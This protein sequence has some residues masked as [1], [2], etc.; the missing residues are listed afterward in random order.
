MPV[1]QRCTT[2][3]GGEKFSSY[4]VSDVG[5]RGEHDSVERFDAPHLINVFESGPYL[6]DGRAATLEEIWTVHNPQDRHGISSDWT[7][8]QLNDLVEYL[9]SL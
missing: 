9:K 3:H 7:Q 6:H 1:G 4:Q 8:Q 5:T 2:C